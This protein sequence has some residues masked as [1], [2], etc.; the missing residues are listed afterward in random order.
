MTVSVRQTMSCCLQEEDA[1]ILEEEAATSAPTQLTM[2][3][4]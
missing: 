2:V 3:T 4:Y 1:L